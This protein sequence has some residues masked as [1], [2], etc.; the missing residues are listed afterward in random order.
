MN[1]TYLY[2][3]QGSQKINMGKDF[4]ENSQKAKQMF[5]EASDALQSDMTKLLFEPNNK[6]NETEFS[7]PAILLVSSI[8]HCLFEK[9]LP[10][11]FALGHS[12]GEISALVGIGALEFSDAIRLVYQRGLLMKKACEGKNAGMMAVIGLTQER[13]TS[14][15]QT[16]AKGK[17][18]WIANINN[19]TQIVL[20]GKKEDLEYIV[21]L[22]KEEG[23]K[24]ALVLPMSVASHCPLLQEATIPFAELLDKCI[25]D[26]FTL[27]IIS[28][29]TAQPYQTKNN[30]V[31]LLTKQLISPVLYTKCVSYCEEKTDIF[32][33]FGAT[34]LGGLNKRITKKPTYSITDMNSLDETIQKISQGI[35]CQR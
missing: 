30:A 7:Q 15:L 9:T 4:Y 5:E 31:N 8:A 21:P 33:E 23:A 34:V 11:Q 10:A 32:I 3:G 24:R 16:E 29:V 2:P 19:E 13:L 28:N 25:E 26:T 6:L 27:P 1:M 17:S 22:L 18:I 20:G 14:F 12:L 35:L